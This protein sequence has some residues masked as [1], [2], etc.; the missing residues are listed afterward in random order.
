MV[1]LKYQS[2][3]WRA[4]EMLLINCDIWCVIVANNIDNPGAP[5]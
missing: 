2:D 4:T 3:F 5:F 1:P